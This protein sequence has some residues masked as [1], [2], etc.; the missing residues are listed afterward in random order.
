MAVKRRVI[1]ATDEE[2]DRLKLAAEAR[3][4]TI[5]MYLR[6][7]A[8]SDE[9]IAVQHTIDAIKDKDLSVILEP[10]PV[11][12]GYDRFNSQPFTGPIPKVRK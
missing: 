10:S 2:W 9:Y 8:M 7:I 11:T 4:V 3:G 6:A 12:V 5:S 1:W